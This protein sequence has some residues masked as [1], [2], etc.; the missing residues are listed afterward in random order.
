MKRLLQFVA[1]A[2][3]AVLS[4]QPVLAGF[5]CT[6]GMGSGAAHC[7]MVMHMGMACH[8]AQQAA[9]LQ[10]RQGSCQNCS[11]QD[12]AQ[13]SPGAKPKAGGISA[14]P[15]VFT[16][17]SATDEAASSRWPAPPA[18]SAPDRYILFQVFRI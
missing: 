11:L 4:A 2:V 14:L 15:A 13:I 16:G 3:I 10:C 1:M 12:A 7:S 5:M 17:I 9:G 8:P 18:I 6:M